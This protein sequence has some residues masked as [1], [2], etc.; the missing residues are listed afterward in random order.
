MCV[1]DAV[2]LQIYPTPQA[3]PLATNKNIMG[4]AGFVTD[5]GGTCQN[6]IP[7][8]VGEIGISR[9]RIFNSFMRCYGDG[10]LIKQCCKKCT[11]VEN[12]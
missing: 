8:L 9:L 10:R 5:G 11:S 3:D 1:D 2:R 6:R 12:L 7:C 4:L